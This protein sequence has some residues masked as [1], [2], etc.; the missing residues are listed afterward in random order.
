[1]KQWAIIYN[2]EV[3]NRI[4]WS[5]ESNW[6]YPFAHDQMI[7]DNAGFY[8]I[9]MVKINNVWTMPEVTEEPKTPDISMVVH[10]LGDA[11]KP[12]IKSNELTAETLYLFQHYILN[13]KQMKLFQQEQSEVIKVKYM[14]SFNHIQLNRI[15]HQI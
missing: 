2:N 5:G 8:K 15:G 14:K 6:T 11:L 7:E 3:V 13:G 4:I 9:G 10:D 12:Y 1:M